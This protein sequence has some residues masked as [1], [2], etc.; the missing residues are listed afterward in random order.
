MNTLFIRIKVDHVAPF[1][2]P[3]AKISMHA[4]VRIFLVCAV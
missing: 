2:F 4:G 3:G 1:S